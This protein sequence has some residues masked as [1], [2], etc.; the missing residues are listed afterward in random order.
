MVNNLQFQRIFSGAT[1]IDK[2][3]AVNLE[4]C[5][6]MTRKCIILSACVYLKNES[7]I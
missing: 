7:I 3:V 2:P 5:V 4:L 1:Y 6:W